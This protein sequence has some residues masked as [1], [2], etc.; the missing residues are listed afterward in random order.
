MDSLY[1][2]TVPY[3]RAAFKIICV[4]E[5]YILSAYD[6]CSKNNILLIKRFLLV[7]VIQ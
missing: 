4:R 7:L 2:E 1:G 3:F 6:N 5:Q